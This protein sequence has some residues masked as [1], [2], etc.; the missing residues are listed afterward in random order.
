MGQISSASQKG[1]P[2]LWLWRSP[3]LTFHDALLWC[4]IPWVEWATSLQPTGRMNSDELHQILLFPFDSNTTF[5]GKL[6]NHRVP[7]CSKCHTEAVAL[8]ESPRFTWVRRDLWAVI[9]HS[10]SVPFFI[11]GTHTLASLKPCRGTTGL[12]C[13]KCGT[14]HGKALDRTDVTGPVS[15]RELYYF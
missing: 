6:L 1:N 3:R 11:V 14:T 2:F 7:Q 9:L 15:E 13:P 5:W 12:Y 4:G 8:P 10:R